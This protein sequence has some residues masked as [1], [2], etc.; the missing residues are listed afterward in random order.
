MLNATSRIESEEDIK[1]AILKII[2]DVRGLKFSKFYDHAYKFI[3]AASLGNDI[4]NDYGVQMHE[5]LTSIDDDL[6]SRK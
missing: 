2:E 6:L 3:A 1:H 4:S 5:F